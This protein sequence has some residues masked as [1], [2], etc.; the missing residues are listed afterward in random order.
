MLVGG[1]YN[2][3]LLSKVGEPSWGGNVWSF[4][5]SFNSVD[6]VVYCRRLLNVV[7][8]TFSVKATAQVLPGVSRNIITNL[9]AAMMRTHVQ[10]YMML[11]NTDNVPTYATPVM[12]AIRPEESASNS[13]QILKVDGATNPTMITPGV[14]VIGTFMYIANDYDLHA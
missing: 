6:S 5:E 1:L 9:P 14:T 8:V 13:N 7:Q 4:G 2:N 12:C 11:Y 3:H 10:A